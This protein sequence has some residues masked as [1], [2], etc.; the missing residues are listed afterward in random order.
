MVRIRTENY[1]LDTFSGHIAKHWMIKENLAYQKNI[2]SQL[3]L[4]HISRHTIQDNPAQQCRKKIPG[5]EERKYAS[6]FCSKPNLSMAILFYKKREIWIV[7]SA[8]RVWFFVLVFGCELLYKLLKRCELSLVDEVELLHEEDEVLEA[9]VEVGLL[10][11]FNDLWEVLVV[12]VGVHA[13]QALQDGLG[14]GQEV[15]REG[16]AWKRGKGNCNV[17]L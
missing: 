12:D 15:F 2:A 8:C 13:E 16:H 14:D 17:I 3:T 5:G 9:G 6:F 10:A 4:V 11:Q 1:R 7:G